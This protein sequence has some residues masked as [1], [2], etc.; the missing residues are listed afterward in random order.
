MAFIIYENVTYIHI[1][2]YRSICYTRIKSKIYMLSRFSYQL[3]CQIDNLPNLIPL[4]EFTG[5]QDSSPTLVSLICQ[6]ELIASKIYV[7][8]SF[9]LRG[10]LDYAGTGNHRNPRIFPQR[11]GTLSLWTFRFAFQVDFIFYRCRW[12][13][14]MYMLDLTSFYK[15]PLHSRYALYAI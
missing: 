5:K 7:T 13:L 1:K 14:R 3:V 10:H 6:R 4:K 2:I 15:N 8:V 12:G 11:I 9:N